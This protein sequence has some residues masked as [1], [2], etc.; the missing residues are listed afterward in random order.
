MNRSAEVFVAGVVLATVVSGAARAAAQPSTILHFR[1][2][3]DEIAVPV[4]AGYCEPTGVYADRAQLAAAAD[5][6]NVT[7]L[8]LFNCAE[9]E[10]GG[11]A[12][13]FAYIKIPKTVLNARVGL[14]ELLSQLGQVPDSEMADA[15]SDAKTSS[16]VAN[17]I[18]A[19][20]GRD[21]AVHSAI[22]PVAR[23]DIAY[24]LAGTLQIKMEGED[25]ALAVSISMTSVKNH[26]L[27]YNFYVPGHDLAA[28][29]MALEQTKTET[30]RLLAA[31]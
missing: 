19:I 23:D 3:G 11:A 4:P 28:I 27:T 22:N 8:S 7:L 15:V 6:Q 29:R 31:N 16:G 2:A 9:M 14:A 17:D 26:M 21:V 5:S 1:L 12:Q 30:R 24:Y 20:G 10:A 18:S 25:I 13:H